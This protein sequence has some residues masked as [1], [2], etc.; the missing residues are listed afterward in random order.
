MLAEAGLADFQGS[1]APDTKVIVRRVSYI[2]QRFLSRE[3]FGAIQPWKC[4]RDAKLL[5]AK[6]LVCGT[7][8][9]QNFL[10]GE[11]LIMRLCGA[12]LISMPLALAL[13]ARA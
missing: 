3:C 5:V 7:A 13:T 1:F 12:C 4:V 6:L 11:L 9:F 2:D 10:W 8:K